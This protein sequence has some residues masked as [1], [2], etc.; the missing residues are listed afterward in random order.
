[1]AWNT[2]KHPSTQFKLYL[3]FDTTSY[4]YRRQ[5]SGLPV[6]ISCFFIIRAVRSNSRSPVLLCVSGIK[7]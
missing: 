2:F 3:N 5:L 1:M 4:T 7:T 6:R